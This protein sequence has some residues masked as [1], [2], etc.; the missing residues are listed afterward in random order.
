MPPLLIIDATADEKISRLPLAG[1]DEFHGEDIG[2]KIEFKRIK[3]DAPYMTL[4]KVID[5]PYTKMALKPKAHEVIVGEDG[6]HVARRALHG[7]STLASVLRVADAICG[8]TVADGG[9]TSLITFKAVREDITERGADED[10]IL[11]H[12]GKT[13]GLNCMENTSS[14]FIAGRIALGIDKLEKLACAI[15]GLDPEGEEPTLGLGM[16]YRAEAVLRVRGA[17]GRS[18]GNGLS[19]RTEAPRCRVVKRVSDWITIA[20]E[21]QAIHR[22]RGVRRTAADP[23][24][25]VVMSNVVG[26][27]T[28]DHVVTWDA[29]AN[30]T[31][32]DAL[33]HSA[34]VVNRRPAHLKALKP[35]LFRGLG[36]DAAI[37]WDQFDAWDV[38]KTSKHRKSLI[39]NRKNPALLLR[40]AISDVSTSVVTRSPRVA[41]SPL[42]TADTVLHGNPSA[43]PLLKPAH[44]ITARYRPGR[45][46][47]QCF[48]DQNRR[49]QAS[50]AQLAAIGTELLP[51]GAPP[52]DSPK[53]PPMTATERQRKR[54]AAIKAAAGGPSMSWRSA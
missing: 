44:V 1:R 47:Y 10:L 46:E 24:L 33:M 53:P 49:T 15:F 20:E 48:I 4:V 7:N 29:F 11:G 18:L 6:E 52:A 23:V 51:E 38:T 16:N 12:L 13:R 22:G 37:A 19:I 54:R 26:D 42:F 43:H 3:V 30:M 21:L 45:V 5:A 25:V 2:K 40:K 36:R 50:A 9:T 27:I 34:G 8:R 14:I 31:A 41:S 28:C 35:P 32:L 39:E 17:D